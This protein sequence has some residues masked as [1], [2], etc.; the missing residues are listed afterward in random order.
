M[1]LTRKELRF[2]LMA[3]RMMN[4]GTFSRSLW[5]RIRDVILPDNFMKYLVT[6]R[7]LS[8]YKHKGNP[9]WMYYHRRYQKLGLRLGFSIGPDVFGYGL[10]LP[11]YGTIIVGAKNTIGNY[12]F[13]HACTCITSTD[14]EIGDNLFL[15]VG[16]KIVSA[17]KLGNNVTV[18]ANSVVTKP[19][20]EDNILLAGMPAIIKGTRDPWFVGHEKFVERRNKCEEL[21]QQLGINI[22]TPNRT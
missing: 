10:I 22:S 6:M 16:A 17:M 19:F 2:Y 11:H 12:A 4:R 21:R 5:Q 3:D 14:H 9:I 8:Y 1:I 20:P 13:I 18:A 7:K 15:S